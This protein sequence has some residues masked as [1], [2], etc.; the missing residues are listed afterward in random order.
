MWL[1][2]LNDLVG[3]LKERIEQHRDV[4]SNN[5][6]ATRY[7]LIDPLLTALG[8]DLQDPGQ[9]QVEYSTGGGRA[10]YAML[11]GEDSS[12]PRLIVEAK[13]LDRPIG[14]GIKQSINYCTEE[15]ILY[16][17]V[18]NGKDWAA[19]ETHKPVPTPD[20]QIVEFHLTD[21]THSTVVKMLWLWRG[22][23]ES[24]SPMVPIVPERPAP[25]QTVT[26]APQPA[27]TEPPSNEQRPNRGIPL[28]EFNP[29]EGDTPPTALLFPDGTEKKIT[30]WN[31]IKPAV[32]RWLINTKRLTEADCPLQ[33]PRG[34]LL[35]S[36]RPFKANGSE[37]DTAKQIGDVWIDISLDAPNHVRHAKAILTARGVDPSLVRV[38][39]KT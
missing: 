11:A 20:K 31:K 26:P 21:A 5:E 33:G 7:A 36:T 28:G 16:F 19:Y 10:D 23:F 15:G 18:T 35:V 2:D 34:G 6:T 1:D 22:N 9:V 8:W 4:L 37:F 14:D 13:K 29:K 30:N 17:V 12:R 25:Q 24:E 38:V 32:V 3:K 27:A 39:R